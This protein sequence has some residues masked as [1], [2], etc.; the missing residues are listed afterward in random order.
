MRARRNLASAV[1]GLILAVTALFSATT[2]AAAATTLQGNAGFTTWGTM[3]CG[4]QPWYTEMKGYLHWK[5]TEV[6]LHG[7]VYWAL[8]PVSAAVEINDPGLIRDDCRPYL[9]PRLFSLKNSSGT[10]VASNQTANDSMSYLGCMGYL[11]DP[12]YWDMSQGCHQGS[13]YFKLTHPAGYIYYG[14]S[15]LP[16]DGLG[17]N[18][19][20]GWRSLGG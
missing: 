12:N 13:Y 18:G 14:A 8:G 5:L 19:N 20:T 9:T 1:A 3:I 2:P 17:L 7:G 4:T 10:V 16:A 11:D 15:M 6:V